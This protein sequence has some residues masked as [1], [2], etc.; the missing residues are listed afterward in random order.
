MNNNLKILLIISGGIA[1]YKSLELIRIFKKNNIK[2]QVVLTK[3][4]AQFVTPLSI[5][6][7]SEEK[8]YQ[9][10]FSLKDETEMGH[11]QLSRKNDLILVAPASANIIAHV[12]A[13]IANDLAT[14]IIL[15]A[16]KPVLFAP[17]MNVE[18][19]NNSITKNNV[20]FLKNNN[21]KFVGPEPGDLA[22]GEEG[23]GRM[24]EPENIKKYISS[25]FEKKKLNIDVLVTAGP[26][27]EAIDP[28]RFIGNRSSGKQ[29]IAI[30][31]AFSELGANVTLVLGPSSQ[32][33]PEYIRVINIE[34]AKDMLEAVK[35][36]K[37]IDVA[38]CAAAVSD[39]A[40][41]NPSKN[42]IKKYNE[43]IPR[44]NFALNP[45]ILAY[46]SNKKKDRPKLV[47]GFAA[48]TNNLINNAKDKLKSKKCDWIIANNVLEEPGVF[49]GDNNNITLITKDNIES[50]DK[51]SKTKVAK[52]LA[53]K[54][55]KEILDY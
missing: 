42:K 54:V 34:T 46:I 30:A 50:W 41:K 9:D 19:W 5:A 6:A 24:S 29:G 52:K 2:V 37:N 32:T 13:G 49:G 26:T 43:K 17:S 15:A 44:I 4:G 22:C 31:K 36:I 40:I 25:M 11:I 33:V 47:I 3:G 51:C 48:E 23:N 12:A 7:L 35:T 14:T 45:D 53:S 1:A 28:V 20:Q 55:I 39:W 8:V 18:M 16:N 27:F 10:L 38:I 21:Y